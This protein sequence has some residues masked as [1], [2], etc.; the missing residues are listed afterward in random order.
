MHTKH[1]PIHNCPQCQI[2][3]HFTAPSPNV[4]TPIFS[5]ALIVE[6][7]H[8]RYLTRFV[9]PPDECYAFRVT[10]F[11]CEKEKEGFYAVESTIHKITW[12]RM[13]ISREKNE[14]RNGIHP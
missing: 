11:E 6:S 2:V 12:R 3:K 5:L 4:P 10:N 8:L 9:V 13:D 7:V 1:P 14:V